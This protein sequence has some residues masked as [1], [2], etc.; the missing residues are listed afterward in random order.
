[1]AEEKDDSITQPSS[2]SGQFNTALEEKKDTPESY[3]PLAG[4]NPLE[5]SKGQEKIGNTGE[6]GAG[7]GDFSASCG[8]ALSTT[9]SHS[10]SDVQRGP[11]EDGGET[12]AACERDKSE[13]IQESVCKRKRE[14]SLSDSID[15]EVTDLK[16]DQDEDGCQLTSKHD[17]DGPNLNSCDEVDKVKCINGNSDEAQNILN[18]L[19]AKL[20][21]KQLKIKPAV[22]SYLQSP[23]GKK[24]LAEV[25]R[26]FDC[27]VQLQVTWPVL[28]TAQ[29]RQ[30]HWLLVCGGPITADDRD[31]QVLVLPLCEESPAAAD[32]SPK[33]KDWTPEYKQILN[34]E[35]MSPDPAVYIDIL[36][37]QKSCTLMLKCPRPSVSRYI[38]LMKVP[39]ASTGKFKD[40]LAEAVLE[41]VKTAVECHSDMQNLCIA[42]PLGLGLTDKDWKAIL[43]AVC[44]TQSK[45]EGRTKCSR[46]V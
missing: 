7:G 24:W 16:E 43:V 29:S 44:E 35:L 22:E 15:A 13:L 26:S 4:E 11:E 25:Q 20:Y 28:L 39:A 34:A 8:Q 21:Q 12:S 41:A 5:N 33:Y 3:V 9:G 1:M 10:L 38:T 14:D 46:G 23:E 18:G 17:D 37:Q 6:G 2:D 36:N 45:L 31:T 30:G 40:H 32:R 42:L 19:L 27:C